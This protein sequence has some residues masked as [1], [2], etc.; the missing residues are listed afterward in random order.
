MH[1]W[2][3]ELFGNLAIAIKNGEALIGFNK[4]RVTI[5][6]SGVA[7]PKA[8]AKALELLPLVGE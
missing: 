5:V 8:A 6:E 3:R 2:R 7:S 4:G 1:G